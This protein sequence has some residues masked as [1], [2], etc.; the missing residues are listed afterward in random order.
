MYESWVCTIVLVLGI[1]LGY[2]FKLNLLGLRYLI[3]LYS[4]KWYNSIIHHLLLYFVFTTTGHVSFHHHLLPALLSPLSPHPHFPLVM[5][6]V[7]L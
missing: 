6:V 3:E 2:N 7:Y 4:L 5:I 1:R